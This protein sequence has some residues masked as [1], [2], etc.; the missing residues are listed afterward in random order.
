MPTLKWIGLRP[1]RK[2]IINVVEEVAVNVTGLVG[3]RY[4][5]EFGNRNVTLIREEGLEDAWSKLGKEGK[6]DPALARRNLV[7]EG[8]GSDLK[9]MKGDIIQIGSD[10]VLENYW[11]LS[12]MLKNGSKFWTR[13]IKS[14]G[15]TW[16]FDRKS[17]RNGSHKSR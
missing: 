10:V 8:L 2:G 3:D 11:L 6:V 5:V 17:H 7:L 4:N 12:P 1:E 9:N 15:W 16:W 14:N 13:W